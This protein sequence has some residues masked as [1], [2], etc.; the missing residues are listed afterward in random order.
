M[1]SPEDPHLDP[2]PLN[3]EPQAPVQVVADPFPPP[4]FLPET[5]AP[6]AGENPVW[7]GWDVLLI[8]GLTLLM[9]FVTQLVIAPGVLRFVYP[10]V[11]WLDLAQKPISVLLA[12]LLSYVVVALYMMVLVQVKYH[13]RFWQAIRWSWPGFV[14]LSMF[15]VGV[16]MLAFDILG[17]YLPMPK[18]TPFDQFF[19]K[20]SDAYLTV[21]FAVTLGPLMEEL[22][23]RGFLYPVI[24]RRMGVVWGILLTAMPFGLMH[25][26]QYRSW[27]A[28]LIVSLVG[29]VLTTVRAA[30]K[31]VASSFLAHVGYNGT[32][33][34]L[35]ALQTDGFRHMEKAAVLLA[36]LKLGTG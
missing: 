33:M 9:L 4:A 12:Q 24:A 31:S 19:D 10:R 8:A 35:A 5:P 21:A 2:T 32:L 26:L 23:F 20:P 16:L 25:Y 6:K 3:A 28:V 17:R 34:V 36:Y 22:F 15:G 1:A 29:V 30:T 7:S 27:G 14:G 18:T 13:T 11:P